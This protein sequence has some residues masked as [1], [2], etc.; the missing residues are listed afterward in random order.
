MTADALG[1]E[2]ITA[3]D[4]MAMEFAPARPVV[5]GLIGEGLTILAG[6]PKVGKSMLMLHV[7]VAV[8]TAGDAMGSFPC[9]AANVLYVILEDGKRRVQERLRDMLGSE[10]VPDRLRFAFKCL[11]LDQGGLDD[12]RSACRAGDVKLLILDVLEAIRPAAKPQERYYTWDY[13]S[14]RGL[15]QVA[16]ELGMAIAVVH[17]DRKEGSDNPINR[18]SGTQGLTGAADT[19]LTLSAGQ[20]LEVRSRDLEEAQYKLKFENGCWSV[21]GNPEDAALTETGQ[22]VKECLRASGVEMTPRQVADALGMKH[23]TARQTLLRL[24]KRDQIRKNSRGLYSI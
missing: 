12:L 24:A 9:D 22:R 2:I 16:I 4:L 14:L 5:P 3:S 15:H 7:A 6:P 19:I 10:P 21:D 11:R 18:V 13:R 8:A 23:D 1:M 17:H 20:L